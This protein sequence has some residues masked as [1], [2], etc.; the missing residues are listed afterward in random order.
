[1]DKTNLLVRLAG[2]RPV[3]RSRLL[4]LNHFDVVPVDAKAWSIDPFGAILRDGFIWGRGTLD[5]KGHRS[6][7][8]DGAW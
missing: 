7:A 6:P 8:L 3:R 5:M 2:P 4:L 1:M